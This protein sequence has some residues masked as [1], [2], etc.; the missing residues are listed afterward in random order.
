LGE[1]CQLWSSS[2]NFLHPPPGFCSQAC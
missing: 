2:C 1:E